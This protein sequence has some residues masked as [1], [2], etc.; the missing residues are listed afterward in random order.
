MYARV[1]MQRV[2]DRR[3][4]LLLEV[5]QTS[6]RGA[7]TTALCQLQTLGTRWRH[8]PLRDFVSRSSAVPAGFAETAEEMFFVILI[9]VAPVE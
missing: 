3:P 7:A 4:C 5:K 2:D 9:L 1:N 6:I 8:Q